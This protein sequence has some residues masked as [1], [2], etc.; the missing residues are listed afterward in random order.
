[1]GGVSNNLN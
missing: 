1:M